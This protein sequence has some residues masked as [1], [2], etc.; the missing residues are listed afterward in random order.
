[1][2]TEKS[3]IVSN[4]IKY[5]RKLHD[6]TQ[7]Q[8]SRRIG[9]KR[10][11]LGAYEEARAN[12]N[13]DNLMAM[14]RAFNI[15][16]DHLLKQ[17]LRK[18]RDT[19]DLRL[20]LEREIEPPL[21]PPAAKEP[22]PQSL[23]RI[24]DQYHKPPV[25]NNNASTWNAAPA[26][27][28]PP[29]PVSEPPPRAAAAP[30]PVAPAPA[31]RPAPVANYQPPVFNNS[32][33]GSASPIAAPLPKAEKIQSQQIQYVSQQNLLEYV[34]KLQ[35]TNYI[36]N[37]PVFQMPLLPDGHYRAF[38]AGE[39]FA[40]SGAYLIGQFVRNWYDIADG[41]SYVLVARNM[42]LVYRRLFNQVKIKG[43]LLL[44]S[45]KAGIPTFELPIKDVVEVWEIKAFF[46]T[47]LPNPTVSLDHLRH[48]SNQIQEELDRIKK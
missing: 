28:K 30:P 42:G 12:P 7:E 32:Y 40:Y 19:P 47:T 17:D 26:A 2:A 38:E 5:L 24:F 23:G 4:N 3:T 14:A 11:L 35:N 25:G 13:L 10:S 34:E 46:S 29:A 31:P 27:P 43:T 9:I 41:K 8:F 1:M 16:V 48:L 36:S 22:E 18:I 20:P 45:D 44:S 39:D 21:P 6:L 33:E 15:Q 37:L